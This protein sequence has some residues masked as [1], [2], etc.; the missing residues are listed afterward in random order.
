[1]LKSIEYEIE[2]LEQEKSM[3]LREIDAVEN[4]IQTYKSQMLEITRRK[5]NAFYY[6]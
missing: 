3:G 4:E 6:F 1:M 5:I 2:R